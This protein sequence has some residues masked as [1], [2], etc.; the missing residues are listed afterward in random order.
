[1]ITIIQG[2][3]RPDSN[4]EFV[5]RQL[6][7]LINMM[8]SGPVGYVS[9]SDL[10]P[11]ILHS[12]PYDGGSMPRKLVNIQ[13][14]FLIPAEKLVWI[15]PEYNGSFPG[16]LKL[17]IDALSVRN[18]A[19]TFAGKKSTVIGITTGRS[20]N[21]RGIDHLVSVL[22]HLRSVIYPRLLPISRIT[23][24]IDEEKNLINEAT[25]RVLD[26][27]LRGFLDF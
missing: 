12:D 11:E 19:Q 27:H 5:S 18:P 21:I 1:M 2:T 16:V 14:Q 4:T 25:I 3:N 6:Q 9:M 15:I 20:G 24:L 10:P 26:D 17:F 23:D 8:Y 7:D 13:D 22:M